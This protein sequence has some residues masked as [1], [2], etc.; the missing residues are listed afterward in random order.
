MVPHAEI[1]SRVIVLVHVVVVVVAVG[2]WSEVCL[3]VL[4]Y[5]AKGK[6]CAE[7]CEY[8]RV[9]EL[10]ENAWQGMARHGKAWQDTVMLLQSHYH[11]SLL[12]WLLGDN[13]IQF[14]AECGGYRLA[15]VSCESV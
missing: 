12:V 4:V 9:R 3:L 14:F 2:L 11:T 8:L 13:D 1:D 10:R 6:T 7:E 5:A 15:S